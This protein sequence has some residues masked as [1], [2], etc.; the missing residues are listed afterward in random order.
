MAQRAYKVEVGKPPIH[1][2]HD[3]A[4]VREDEIVC[5]EAPPFSV[6]DGKEFVYSREEWLNQ[7]IR[8]QRNSLLTGTDV[9]QLSDVQKMISKEDQEAIAAYRQ[10]LR[11]FPAIV[12]EKSVEWPKPPEVSLSTEIADARKAKEEKD[13]IVLQAVSPLV[14]YATAPDEAAKTAALEEL[15]PIQKDIETA[16][17]AETALSE[18][19]EVVRGRE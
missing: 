1:T 18:V 7:E 15:A 5:E 6:W 13:E 4:D 19:S 16:T 9:Y 8:P 12:D 10:A 17:T 11:D 14:K 2:R 3:L